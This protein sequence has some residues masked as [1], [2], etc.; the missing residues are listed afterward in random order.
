MGIFKILTN[1]CILLTHR[2][3]L[4]AL[5]FFQSLCVWWARAEGEGVGKGQRLEGGSA[6]NV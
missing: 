1:S 4:K 2:Q 6:L 5:C 3:L